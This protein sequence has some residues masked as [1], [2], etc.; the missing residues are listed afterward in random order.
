V[1]FVYSQIW[2]WSS[3]GNVLTALKRSRP[4]HRMWWRRWHEMTS[5]IASNHVNPTGIALSMQKG[6]TLKGMEANKNFNKWLSCARIISGT[7]G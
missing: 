3:S 5:S 4:N 1:T 7:F 6:T 2:Y